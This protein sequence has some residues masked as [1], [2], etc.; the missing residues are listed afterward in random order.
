MFNFIIKLNNIPL[1]IK[2]IS[3]LIYLKNKPVSYPRRIL[4]TQL[5]KLGD[6]VCTTPMFMAV[7]NK[8][9]NC[10]VWIMGNALNK[11]LIDGNKNVDGY[12]VYSKNIN[13]TIQQ[14]RD[15]GFDFA[16]VTG[17]NFEALAA[18]IISGIKTIAV[19]RI[20]NG[21][22]P[23]ET[24][25]YKILSKFV[26]TKPHHM[27]SYAPRE[28]LRLLEPIGV[29][30]DDT[31]KHLAF[32]EVGARRAGEILKPFTGRFIVG[33]APGAGNKIKEWSTERFA[34]VANYLA[35]KH[36][37]AIVI[38]GG[39]ND[40]ALTEKMKSGIKKDI[41]VLDTTGTL[42]VDELKALISK[43]NL[44]ISV[45]TGPIYIA[46]AF[47]VPTIDIVGP[48]DENEQPPIS[49]I[50]RVVVPQNRTKSQLHIMNARIYNVKEARR[51]VE[52]ITIQMV[53]NAID[54]IIERLNGGG[55]YD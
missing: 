44:F 47:G 22:S 32:S 42:S 48:M 50:H 27:G 35:E 49:P 45:D 52:S 54:V 39:Q 7:K 19:P 30:T 8:Y 33:I 5:A 53:T 43:L 14:V 17:P 18:L 29:V 40:T 25:L 15:K 55:K 11:E 23:Y 21:F 2:A 38:I 26:I 37:A 3:R 20:R 36:D 24:R 10:E 4:I 6:M 9:P 28:Y 51:Q 13:D 12:I 31:A 46:E 34:E 1:L 41:P 16:C